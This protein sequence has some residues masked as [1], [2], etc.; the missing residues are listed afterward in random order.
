MYIF[1]TSR[2]I[3]VTCLNKVFQFQFSV[4]MSLVR[5]LWFPFLCSVVV[6]WKLEFVLNAKSTSVGLDTIFLKEILLLRGMCYFLLKLDQVANVFTRRHFS[7]ILTFSPCSF[8]F[9]RADRTMRGHVLGDPT[10]RSKSL[11]SERNLSSVVVGITRILMHCAM[12]EG[13]CR[14]PQVC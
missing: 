8:F 4:A 9:F 12:I 14:Q 11:A 10:A 7:D 6:L 5:H 3:N 1:V 13:A 2:L